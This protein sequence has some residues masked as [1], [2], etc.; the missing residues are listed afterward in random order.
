MILTL[1][2]TGC[3]SQ[4][5]DQPHPVGAPQATAQGVDKEGYVDA[6]SGVRLSYRLV[7]TGGDPVIL[8]HGG[9]GFTS[10]YLADDMAPMARSRSVFIYD[11]RGIGKSTLVSDSEGLAAQRYVEDLEAIRKHLGLE[12]LT[13]LGH[14]RGAAPAALY[15]IQYP[16]RVRR[17][18][19]VGTIPLRRSELVA[20]FEKLAAGRD[21]ATQRRM[22]ALSRIRQANPGDLRACQEYYR[23]WF[24][25]FFAAPRTPDS[26]KGSVCA[27]SPASLANKQFVDRFTFPS[28]GDWDWATSLRSAT[29]PTLIIHGELDPL[30]IE[31]ARKWATAMPNAR[32]LELKGIGHFPYVE[33]PDA[34]FTASNRF[35]QGDWPEGTAR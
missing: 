27:G 16:H 32:L 15:A 30:P 9:P 4:P 22:A 14:S 34:F 21:S 26:M 20:A 7:G 8:I 3:T 6:G 5:A 13:L 25:P 17:M 29:T 35:L 33:A 24:T 23:L 12:Q 10:D 11:Q 18:I 2:A 19:L 1:V 31:S 28:L